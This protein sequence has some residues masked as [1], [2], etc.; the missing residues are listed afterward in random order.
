MNPFQ[1]TAGIK[2]PIDLFPRQEAEITRLT[3]G[4][5]KATNAVEKARR[6]QALVEEVNV[7]LACQ[8]YDEENLDC[9]LCHSISQLR[10]E[11]AALVIKAAR[12]GDLRRS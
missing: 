8:A 2:C 9:H 5:N 1:K 12:L 10:H 3:H 7:L 4:I 11:T 6:A